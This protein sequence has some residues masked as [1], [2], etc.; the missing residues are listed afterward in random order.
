MTLHGRVAGA[1]GLLACMCALGLARVAEAACPPVA[2]VEGPAAMA[3]AT[4][5]ILRRHGVESTPNTCGG[6]MVRALLTADAGAHSYALRI[7]DGFGRTNERL[8]GDAETAASLIESW[9]LD[10]DADLLA[11][12]LVSTLV[13]AA[14]AASTAA[15]VQAASPVAAP[16]VLATPRWRLFG[17]GEVSVGA[18]PATWRG[19]SATGCRHAGPVCLGGRAR[20]GRARE[21]QQ[22]PL[23]DAALEQTAV[24]ALAIAAV[25][26]TRGRLTLLPLIGLGVGWTRSSLSRAPLT[27]SWDDWGPRAEAALVV[28][29]RV[30][31]GWSLL[32]ELG[33]SG[34]RTRA[35]EQWEQ[36]EQRE[37]SASTFLRPPTSTTTASLLAGIGI[38]YSR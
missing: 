25:P 11:P 7:E 6:R 3:S 9:V 23:F 20:M 21:W 34:G 29:V 22:E 17:V 16:P 32:A 8:A 37:P 18:E 36:W 4:V 30:G 27:M 28:D 13:P 2:I 33:A 15:E 1:L 10:E 31:A 38:G 19:G 12:R 14:A 35:R 5:A 24:D 26:L